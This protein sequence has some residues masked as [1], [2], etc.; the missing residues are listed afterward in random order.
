MDFSKIDQSWT[1]FLD[2]DGVINEWIPGDYVRNWSMFEFVEGSKTAIAK[3]SQIFGQ[4]FIVTNQRG[5]HKGLMSARDLDQV[6]DLMLNE[7][8][9]EGGKITEVYYCPEDNGHP[10]RKPGIGMVL[11]AQQKYPNIDFSKSIMVGDK[12]ADMQM[13]K[14]AKMYSVMVAENESEPQLELIDFKFK[15]LLAFSDQF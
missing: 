9:V 8:E 14:N 12:N 11:K 6:H 13:A 5:I 4:I 15:N 1:L 2:R 3:L 7:I 10:D